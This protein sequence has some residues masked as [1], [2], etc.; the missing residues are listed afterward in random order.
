MNIS[1]A[2]LQKIAAPMFEELNV[3]KLYGTTDGQIFLL[4]SRARLHAGK[5]LTVYQLDKEEPEA[6]TAATKAKTPDANAGEGAGQ[7]A[8]ADNTGNNGGGEVLNLPLSVKAI[9]EK[10]AE[11]TNIN[12]LKEMLLAEVGGPNR[13]SAVAAIEKGIE[14]LT[15]G[16]GE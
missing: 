9:T 4:D 6:K 1:K 2:E 7:T 12:V 10:V 13:K 3:K 16:K 5:K 11:E 15:E 8:N 14:K